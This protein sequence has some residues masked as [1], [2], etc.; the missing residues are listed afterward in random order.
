MWRKFFKTGSRT[1]SGQR[2]EI[3]SSTVKFNRK[4]ILDA[5]FFFL[6]TLRGFVDVTKQFRGFVNLSITRFEFIQSFSEI[7]YTTG[8]R[9][10]ACVKDGAMLSASLELR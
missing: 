7:I 10:E 6:P 4:E 1:V 2:K 5:I 9:K 3:L 8:E